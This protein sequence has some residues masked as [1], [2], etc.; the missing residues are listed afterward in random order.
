MKDKGRTVSPES[1]SPSNAFEAGKPGT[2]ARS[3]AEAAIEELRLRGGVF[4]NAVR[5][6][7]MPMVLPYDLGAK[8][9]VRFE[10]DG[11]RFTMQL[12][13]RHVVDG[14]PAQA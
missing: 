13:I 9:D 12:P 10:S 1:P 5:A 7:R 3:D 8:T 14:S 6:T 11:I 2:N 4:V